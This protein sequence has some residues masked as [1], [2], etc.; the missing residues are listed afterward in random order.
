MGLRPG[1]GY[2]IAINETLPPDDQ[3]IVVLV[4]RVD[5]P[6]SPTSARAEDWGN[7]RLSLLR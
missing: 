5:G 7:G 2:N 4:Y 3:A 6:K 1:K